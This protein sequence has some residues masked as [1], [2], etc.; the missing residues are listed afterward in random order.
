MIKY[1]P[2]MDILKYSLREEEI[3]DTVDDMLLFVFEH[4]RRVVAFMGAK[5]PF[6]PDEI[7]IGSA[8][9]E[10]R[11]T[12]WKEEHMVFVR[13]MTDRVFSNPMCIGFCGK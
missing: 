4:W 3:F 10:N 12:G 13:R 8:G 5:E 9:T 11:L 1:R 6:R 7:T 2:N